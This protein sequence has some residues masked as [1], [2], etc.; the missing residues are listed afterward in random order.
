MISS[1][2]TLWLRPYLDSQSVLLNH[3]CDKEGHCKAFEQIK[4]D[5]L[6]NVKLYN[7]RKSSGDNSFA[8]LIFRLYEKSI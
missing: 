5:I 4:S 8:V 6:C 2:K 1:L 3:K 7:I